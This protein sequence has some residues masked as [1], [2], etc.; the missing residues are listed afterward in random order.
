MDEN[1]N[2]EAIALATESDLLVTEE[3]IKAME[4]RPEINYPEPGQVPSHE[5]ESLHS[6]SMPKNLKTIEED[7]RIS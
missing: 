5:E 3:D 7:G 2:G 1:T 6:H 4:K